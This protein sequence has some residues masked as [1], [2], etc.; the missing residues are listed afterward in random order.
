M[1]RRDAEA[2]L[3]K[4]IVRDGEAIYRKVSG[5]DNPFRFSIQLIEP[6]YLDEN[7]NAYLPNGDFIRMGV[8]FSGAYRQPIA[9]HLRTVHPG[10]FS[11]LQP[12]GSKTIRVPASE[13]THLFLADYIEQSR[14]YP[15]LHTAMNR[16]NMLG[17]YEEA[18]L[19][20]ARVAASKMAFLKPI[21][22][23]NGNYV[24]DDIDDDGNPISEAE[25][26]VIEQLPNGFDI[27]S[28]DWTHPHTEHAAFVKAMLRGVAA[29]AGCSYTGLSNDLE[30]VNYSSIRAGLLDE[31]DM[32]MALQ[33][34]FI[35]NV[36]TDI[37]ETWLEM[38]LLK[39]SI[40]MPNGSAL[41]A[42]RAEKFNAPIFNGRRWSWVDP[43]KDVQAN[44]IAVQ[45]GFKS[46]QQVVSDMGG[47]RE[48]VMR[49]AQKDE[50][51]Q[52]FYGVKFGEEESSQSVPAKE[53][54]NK[55][56]ANAEDPEDN[57]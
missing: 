51:L 1:G 24:G 35:S 55:E 52:N 37:F 20:A 6:D 18:A 25:A 15:W 38:A 22:D 13:I 2:M 46:A 5:F 17:G 23:A 54:T 42:A 48:D 53:D 34:W 50:E 45:N 57:S 19:V 31:R 11:F 3:W 29:G 7:Y 9:Y 39:G 28:L 56:P 40:T 49:H 16:L 30:G 36:E 44:V 32:W 27:Q 41:P 8:E 26:G 43:M 33:N 4:Y 12:K 21:P 10:D 14:G 47:D